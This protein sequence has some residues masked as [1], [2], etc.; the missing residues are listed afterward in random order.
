MKRAAFV[1]LILLVFTIS[2]PA[3]AF[4]LSGGLW[5]V[6]EQDLI[7]ENQITYVYR[8]DLTLVEIGPLRLMGSSQYG[9]RLNLIADFIDLVRK[10]LDEEQLAEMDDFYILGG[11]AGKVRIDWP[12]YRQVSLITSVG[13]DVLGHIG[14]QGET[15]E[16]I[17]S[18]LYGGITYGGGLGI[19]I[20]PGLKLAGVY[21]YTP[22][23]KSLVG[24]EDSGSIQ[25]VD[26]SI[27]YQIPVVLAK[28]GYRY[29]SLKLDN[30]GGHRLSGF[31]AGVGIHF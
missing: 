16:D 6:S 2:V 5:S 30:G 28:A 17:T 13:Y 18:G 4:E 15:V 14:K 25:A 1:V 31:Y 27:E 10:S 9:G 29:Q 3:A 22:T 20:V 26:V 11:I 12:V 19:E 8:A 24:S 7:P 23:V 21:E